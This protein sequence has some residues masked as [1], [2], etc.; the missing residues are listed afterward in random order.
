MVIGYSLLV[1][2]VVRGPFVFILSGPT[3]G[4]SLFFG[5]LVEG[6]FAK[7][8]SER[9]EGSNILGNIVLLLHFILLLKRTGKHSFREVRRDDARRN[10]N[11]KNERQRHP[12]PIPCSK[13][14]CQ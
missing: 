3:N 14:G 1:I 8:P 11:K 13:Y 12:A 10:N 4:Y 7:C 9:S 2:R 5:G 6:P